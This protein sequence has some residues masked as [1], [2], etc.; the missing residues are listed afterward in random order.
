VRD[1]SPLARLSSLQELDCSYT[2]VNDLSPLGKLGSL[3]KLICS[4]SDVLHDLSPLA[5][6]VSLQGLNCSETKVSDGVRLVGETG[7]SLEQI[8]GAVAQINLLVS[9]IASAAQE[10]STGLEQVNIAVNQMDQ[11]TQQNAAMVEQSTA[12]SHH[13]A[14]EANLL[15]DLMA[16]FEVGQSSAGAEVQVPRPNAVHAAQGR[17]A[18]LITTE[19]TRANAWAEF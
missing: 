4:N 9:E 3:L 12:A 6:L 19:Q 18:S 16:Q 2:Q 10:Q 11:V 15:A 1:L 13:L 17:V 5:R 14:R 7:K 8:V